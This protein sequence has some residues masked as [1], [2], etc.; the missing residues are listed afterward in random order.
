MLSNMTHKIK[1]SVRDFFSFCIRKGKQSIDHVG[2][3]STLCSAKN[4]KKKIVEMNFGLSSVT[5]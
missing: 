4:K 3:T 5:P 1:V 2:R